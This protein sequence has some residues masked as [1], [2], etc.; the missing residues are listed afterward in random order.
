MR[1]SEGKSERESEWERKRN[2]QESTTLFLSSKYDVVGFV[3]I[4]LFIDKF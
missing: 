4:K 3:N 1:K 2:I